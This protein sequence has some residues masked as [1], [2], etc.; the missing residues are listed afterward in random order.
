MKKENRGKLNTMDDSGF[1]QYCDLI[2]E[3]KD[4]VLK[5]VGSEF[6]CESCG[7]RPATNVLAKYGKEIGRDWFPL[8]G[9]IGSDAQMLPSASR[10]ARICSLCLLSVQFLP[11]GAIIV[12]G[13]IACLQ[14]THTEITQLIINEVFN[15]TVNKLQLLK[16]GEKLSAF[17]KGKG[18][19]ETIIL[20]I[21]IM[22]E[23][24]RNKRMLYLPQHTSL[25]VWLFSNSGQEPDCDV[26]EI[27]NEA[28]VFLWDAAKMYRQEIE[29]ILKNEPKRIDFQLLEC[30]KRKS[31][32]YGFYPY[33]G[34]KP[35]SK[36]LFELY[37]TRVLGPTTSALNLAEWLAFQIK[38]R[39]SAGDKNDK[40]LLSKLLK[41]NAY[42]NRDKTVLNKLRGFIAQLAEDD[43]IT[44][45]DYT[46]LFPRE[47]GVH[48]LSVKKDALKWIWFYLNHDE[49]NDTKPKGGDTLFTHPL[50]K[51]FAKDTFNYY[52]K[53]RGL[54]FI[55]RNI[56]DA[57][58]KGEVTTF[59]LQRWFLNLSE[60]K[61]GY[62]NE[63]WDNLCRD[64]N[65]NNVTHEIRFQFRLEMANLYRL[66]INENKNFKEEL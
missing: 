34:S 35:A 47:E 1:N 12:G 16:S 41:E 26:I 56:L 22:G 57:F 65:G 20:L 66:M 27:P 51:T 43:F 5:N 31:E 61:D 25:N 63:A 10:A 50:I 29:T 32:Y 21:K 23:L 38:S 40:K 62:T 37:Q 14:S 30:I 42:G 64:E 11:L 24:Q 46:L 17:G 33:K 7:E 54:K 58:K 18:T 49:I 4:T 3:L 39:L 2:K 6:M 45:E 60:I 9:S 44:L 15:E 55:K 53:E 36:G 13:K 48:Q 19:K 28:L 8:A 52:Q 59:D